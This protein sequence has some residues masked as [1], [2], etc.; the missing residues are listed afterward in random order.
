MVAVGA[1]L[2]SIGCYSVPQQ[3]WLCSLCGGG[4]CALVSI[5]SLVEPR[6]RGVREL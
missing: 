6:G 5:E 1:A 2:A 4:L 3:N